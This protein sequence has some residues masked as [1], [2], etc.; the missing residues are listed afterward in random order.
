[1]RP[2]NFPER[3]RQRKIGV[4]LREN[5]PIPEDLKHERRDVRTKKAKEKRK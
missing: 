2:K 5:L 1:M 3:K 4:L